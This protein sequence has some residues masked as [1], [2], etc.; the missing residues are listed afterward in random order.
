MK[1]V[2]W[3]LK[4]YAA[5]VLNGFPGQK[6]KAVGV[7]GTNGKTTTCYFVDSILNAASF[8]TARMTT[9]D[10]TLG[11]APRPNPVHLTSFGPFDLQKFLR[12][13]KQKKL[14]WTVLELSS[15]GLAQNR[16]L[17]VKLQAAIITYISREHLDFH[18]SVEEYFRAKMKIMNLVDKNGFVVLNRDDKNF[19]VMKK[20]AHNQVISFG[21]LRGDITAQ[22]T[23]YL[24]RG[25]QFLLKTP[26]GSLRVN[27]K[28]PGRFNVYNA[29]AAAAVGYG[30]GIEL[31]KIREGLENM[32][33]VPGR[34]EEIKSPRHNFRV[35]VDYVHTPD[36]LAL[37]LEELRQLTKNKL[38]IVFGMPGLRDPSNRPLMGATA[39]RSADIV[40]LTDE[41]PR[42]EDPLDIINQ[43]G[44]GVKRKIIN[45][46]FFKI[47]DRK[48]A[49]QKALS[50]AEPGDLVLVAGKGPEN[51][52]ELKDQTIEWDDRLV[53]KKLLKEIKLS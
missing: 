33:Y 35:L 39:D 13:V 5:N 36:A 16:V 27:L 52:M 45:K 20:Y 23:K 43:I 49:I 28:M 9:V 3:N 51:Y 24:A 14:D 48:A 8:K 19:E 44:Q 1:L 37:V 32:N 42:T 12:Q 50:L 2:Y 38:I 18:G 11:G 25:S 7:T 34:M 40:I 17:G 41:N 30:L 26:K 47:V 6:I 31:E 22:N 53:T 46:N 21:I 29:L 4:A 15:H 10:Y